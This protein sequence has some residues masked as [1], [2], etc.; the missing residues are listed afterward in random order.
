MNDNGAPLYTR[1]QSNGRLR[2]GKLFLFEGGVRVPMVFSWPGVLEP[3]SIYRKPVSSL[4]VFPTACA[5]GK[6]RLPKDLALDGIDLLPYL[7]GANT[8][9]PHDTLFWSNGPNKAIRFGV[10]KLIIAGEHKFLFNLDRD[11]GETK[12]LAEQK[13]DVVRRLEQS[14]HKWQ[15]QIKPPAWPSK[16]NRRKVDI[17]G[18]PYELNI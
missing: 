8:T 16:P 11:I 4:D 15:S 1:V 5:A 12:N 2:L 6:I 18:V 13:P 10:W 17:D 7:K 14:L 9:T 3:G